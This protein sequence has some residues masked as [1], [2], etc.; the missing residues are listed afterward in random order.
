[1]IGGNMC[2]SVPLVEKNK[3]KTPVEVLKNSRKNKKEIYVNLLTSLR[4]CAIMKT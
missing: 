1:M 4:L 2:L 3:K